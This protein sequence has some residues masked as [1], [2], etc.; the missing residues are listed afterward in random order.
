MMNEQ[1]LRKSYLTLHLPAPVVAAV[2]LATFIAT[3][4]MRVLSAQIAASDSGVGAGG[5]TAIVKL[6]GVALTT[7]AALTVA[8]G[9]A[10]NATKVNVIGTV[11]SYPGGQ[12]VRPGDV[13]TVDVTA[14][15]GTTS[16][17]SVSIILSLTQLD[18]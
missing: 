8:V 6:N 5:T 11:S 9:A 14:V 4:P 15:P 3:H 2:A 7:D 10:V 1:Q 18:V 16:P 17:K 12:S 13:I